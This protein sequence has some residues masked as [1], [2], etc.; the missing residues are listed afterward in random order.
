MNSGIYTITNALTGAQYVGSAVNFNQRWS[1]HICDLKKGSHHS[2]Y[3]QNAWNLYGEDA[4]EFDVILRCAPDRCIVHE[5]G[6][7]DFLKP[8]YNMR[9]T[10]G[11][12]LGMKHSPETLAKM[13]AAQKGRTFSPDTIVKMRDAAINRPPEHYAAISA[14][15]KGKPVPHLLAANVGRKATTATRAKMSEV[16]RGMPLHPN[17]LAASRESNRGRVMSHKTRAT[18][19]AIRTG[20]S[21]SAKTRAKMSASHLGKKQSPETIA[22]RVA[23]RARNRA[24]A[25]RG[26]TLH[27]H[28]VQGAT[29]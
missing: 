8:A 4:F 22:K 15:K 2:K 20:S 9:L 24:A 12:F 13:S 3:L 25:Q 27:T 19:L 29:P 23:T 11:S 14:A 18:L 17:F 5:Q 21:H 6:A 10:V 26:E 7:V 1:R 28:S 16:R